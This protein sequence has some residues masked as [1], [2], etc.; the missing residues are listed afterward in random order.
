[1]V[2]Q[3]FSKSEFPPKKNQKKM[4]GRL[5]KRVLRSQGKKW[6]K[7]SPVLG[8]GSFGDGCSRPVPGQAVCRQN[9]V[10]AEVRTVLCRRAR[11]VL[12][13]SASQHCDS[14]RQHVAQFQVGRTL[15]GGDSDQ[16]RLPRQ[17]SGRYPGCL[18]VPACAWNCTSRR[19]AGQHP[20]LWR[21]LQ[22]D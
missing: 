6:C 19:E 10:Y 17:C 20:V 8:K 13:V 15:R 9:H 12:P 2:R 1:M 22:A 16:G 18:G 11:G 7:K 21:C 3:D 14:L 5:V 4:Q